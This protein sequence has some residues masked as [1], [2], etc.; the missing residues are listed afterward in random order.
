MARL[1]T[2]LA[3]RLGPDH[4]AVAGVLH[5]WP[6]EVGP[7]GASL[8]L[9]LAGG[10]HALRLLDRGDLAPAYPP[11]DAADDRLWQAVSTA[12]RSEEAFLLNWIRRAPQTNEI[13]RAAT[14]RAAGQW[15]TARHGLPLELRE[16][17]ASAGLNLHWDRFAL[18]LGGRVDGPADAALTLAPEWR[19]ALPP[20]AEP[21]IA[22][23]RGVDL[24]PPDPGRDRLRL[25]A[26][27][28]PDQ[29]DRLA[30]TEAAL[31]LPPAPVDAACAGDWLE[32]LD[33]H[34]PGTCRLICHSIAWQ[35]FPPDVQARARAAIERLGRAASDA[36][37]LA[38]FA[39]EA[40]GAGPGAALTLTT[41][42]GGETRHAGRADSHGRWIDWTLT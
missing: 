42:P 35:Y 10:L 27:L 36:A 13:R 41:W 32:A 18:D 38:W 39:M 21:R 26:Y 3:D 19:G 20:P 24:S 6:G 30:R 2:L 40:D 1:M 34:A 31:A 37:P 5:G 23:R 17:G 29:P 4:G 14:F 8:P 16:L 15:L 33:P 28:W 22:T 7:T 11:Q 25:L 12:L 9:R